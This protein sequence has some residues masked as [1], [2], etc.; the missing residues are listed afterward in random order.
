[1]HFVI[2]NALLIFCSSAQLKSNHSHYVNFDLGSESFY[3]WILYKSIRLLL[4]LHGL[5]CTHNQVRI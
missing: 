5:D 4:S 3:D 1:M 2:E